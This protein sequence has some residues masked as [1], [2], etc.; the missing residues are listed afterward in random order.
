[1][2]FLSKKEIGTV[3]REVIQSAVKE[4]YHLVLSKSYNMPD[5]IQVEDKQNTLLLMP[6][7][8]HGF[9]ATKLVSVFPEAGQFDQPAVNG[10]LVLADNR[11]GQ[12]LAVMDGAAITAERTGAVGGLGVDL[13]TPKDI[14]TAG[15]IGAGVQ[16]LSQARY[17]LLNRKIRKLW[18]GDLNPEA[19]PK[20]AATLE[21]EFPQVAVGIPDTLEELVMA[22]QVVIAA[23]TRQP[24]FKDDTALVKGK[25]FI[26]IGSFRP[27]MKEFPDAVI[28]TADHLYVDTL[29]A[30][31]ESGD[32]CIPLAN[33]II[34]SGKIK[35]FADL[36]ETPVSLENK[37]CFFKS[38]GMALFDLT[39]AT[40]VYELAVKEK[41]GYQLGF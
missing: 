38:V 10:V 34:P 4:S 2:L 21:N 12:P 27:D 26:S 20:M 9:F 35:R 30:A 32:I 7:F 19:A 1:M 33:K 39:V 23:T 11:T 6:C 24:L 18:I 3:G 36:L 16:G 22:S 13:L 28:S 40:A 17:L 5:R 41:I 37:T 8:S 15:I 29:F 31:E 25:T 14:E